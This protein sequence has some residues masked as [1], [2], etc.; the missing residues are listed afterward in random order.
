MNHTVRTAATLAMVGAMVITASACGDGRDDLS[1]D[2]Q[3]ATPTVASQEGEP[4]QGRF[5]FPLIKSLVE[6]SGE[7]TFTA[8]YAAT[9]RGGP[10]ANVT[11]ARQAPVTALQLDQARLLWTPDDAYVCQSTGAGQQCFRAGA[12]SENEDPATGPD[13]DW[14]A[15]LADA[16]FDVLSPVAAWQYLEG[17][18]RDGPQ[19][20]ESAET[21]AGQASSCVELTSQAEV[22]DWT[23]TVTTCFLDNGVVA[24]FLVR[25]ESGGQST[26]LTVELTGY[27]ASVDPEAVEV[28]TDAPIRG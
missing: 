13:R 15:M 1:G 14:A 18:G 5:D 11:L 9:V 12:P 28:P 10:A 26:E 8:E 22:Y 2:Q 19:V 27:S 21:I 6:R 25:I 16:G 20:V 4:D 7:V 24:R 17:L 3:T 23:G